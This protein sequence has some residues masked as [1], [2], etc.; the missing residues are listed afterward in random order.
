MRKIFFYN[1]NQFFNFKKQQKLCGGE[2]LSMSQFLSSQKINELDEDVNYYV[3]LSSL[4][5]FIRVNDTQT[6]NFEQ[7]FNS[8]GEN[9]AFICD[10]VYEEDIKYLLRYVFDE[11]VD[12]DVEAENISLGQSEDEHKEVKK[13]RKIT[14]LDEAELE[15]FFNI[16][17]SRL[18]GHDRFKEEFKK[19]LNH[20]ACLIK[21]KNIKY[22]LCF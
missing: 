18:Y 1:R 4:V 22:C 12:I 9:V 8:F 17:D 5:G 14:D 19:S 20:F 6:L 2:L 3:D 10:K 16:F 13:V 21:L 15:A 11:V 7:L